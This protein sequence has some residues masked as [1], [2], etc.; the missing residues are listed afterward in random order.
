MKKIAILTTLLLTSSLLIGDVVRIEFDTNY[1][2]FS[3][4]DLKKRVWKLERA[5]SQLQDKVFLM[6]RS[7][8]KAS[9]KRFTCYVSAFGKTF[10]AT[11]S[12]ETAAKASALQKCS[13]KNNAMHCD[14]IKCGS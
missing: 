3:K 12:T 9:K 1:D 10:T 8:R 11:K 13:E 5:V 7:N 4:R 6:A 2:R 14:D